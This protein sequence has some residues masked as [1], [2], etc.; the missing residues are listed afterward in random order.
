MAA[1]LAPIRITLAQ[2]I[3]FPAHLA[4]VNKPQTRNHQLNDGSF[5][6]FVIVP[7]N[8]GSL[9]TDPHVSTFQLNPRSCF[10]IGHPSAQPSTSPQCRHNQRTH[11]STGYGL[12]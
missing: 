2:V 4:T 10:Q 11:R 1:I 3:F 9:P 7:F 12:C 5:T 8:D 6:P